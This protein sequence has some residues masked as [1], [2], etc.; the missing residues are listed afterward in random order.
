MEDDGRKITI[1]SYYPK[2]NLLKSR[3]TKDKDEE[4]ILKR[5]FFKYDNNAVI[6]EEIV[7]DGISENSDDLTGITE[8]H[9][10]VITPR[11]KFPIGLPKI[12]EEKYWENGEYHLL[13]KIVNMHSKQGKI[14][15]QKHYG[16]DGK[17]AYTLVWEYDRLGHATKEINA[18]GEAMEYGYDENE[19]KIYER[20][21]NYE[22]HMLYDFANRLIKE[23]EFWEDGT[24]FVTSHRYNLLSQRIASVDPFGHETKYRYD[25]QGRLT[26]TKF[27]KT[28][29][30]KQY[31]P[32]GNVIVATRCQRM[33]DKICHTIRG[34]P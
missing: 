13:K 11:T 34:K 12:I 10:K 24:H 5:E 15:S 4:R 18:L 22:K 17:L 25:T 19:N 7:D 3:L 2:S 33:Q 23:E 14:L 32:M 9:V 16:S 20:G 31:D 29:E 6:I 1:S 26:E 8:R 21:P 27:H 30:K 28:V